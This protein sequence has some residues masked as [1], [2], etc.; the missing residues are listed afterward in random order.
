MSNPWWEVGVD[1]FQNSQATSSVIVFSSKEFK[2]G[3]NTS[4]HYMCLLNAIF[5]LCCN[6]S[7]ILNRTIVVVLEMPGQEAV[8]SRPTPVETE[9]VDPAGETAGETA[10]GEVSPSGQDTVPGISM[11]PSEHPE[12]PTIRSPP[13][14]QK[15]EL[16][17]QNGDGEGHRKRGPGDDL[18]FLTESTP[19]PP[20]S[21]SAIYSRMRRMFQPK[22]DGSMPVDDQWNN[23]WKDCKGGGRDQLMAMFEKVGFNPDR[24][25]K[26]VV[27][28]EVW[29]GRFIPEFSKVW[30][31]TLPKILPCW[32]LKDLGDPEDKFK[33]RCRSITEKIAEETSEIEGEW[34][35]VSDMEGLN[36]SEPLD[37]EFRMNT[38]KFLR[39]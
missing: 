3:L 15:S 2:N 38:A 20:L 37:V 12:K 4:Q 19:P 10:G 26:N 1:R 36:F 23:L 13:P 14:P 18:E 24:V 32:V 9:I 7:L 33:K 27:V 25:S 22:T 29:D 16:P 35:T 34:L 11:S 30:W 6:Y 28:R 17:A 5:Y 39:S 21:R 8:L 31:N